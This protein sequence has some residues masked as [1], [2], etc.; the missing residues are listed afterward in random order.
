VKRDPYGSIDLQVRGTMNVCEAVGVQ[1]V[2][3]LVYGSSFYVY[4]GMPEG[5]IVNESTPLAVL[6]ADP[7]GA[8]KLMGE[9][10]VKAWAKRLGFAWASLRFGSVYGWGERASNAVKSMIEAGLNGE[11]FEVWGKGVRRQQ[12]TLIDDVVNG[13]I[14]SLRPE[15][16]GEVWNLISPESTTVGELADA[17]RRYG[18]ETRFDTERSDPASMC[19][20]SSQRA[21]RVLGWS[22]TPLFMG[23]ERVVDEAKA[24]V[25]RVAIS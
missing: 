24:E 1:S 19:Y 18:F 16:D 21:E 14:L 9:L 13:I 23:L 15:A 2:R 20:M 8:A 4:S 6:D 25:N 3:K 5:S 11:V 12:Y 10:V 7:F 22:P 17:L